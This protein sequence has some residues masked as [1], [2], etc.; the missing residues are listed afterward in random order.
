MTANTM[1]TN[2]GR[3]GYRPGA[4]RP[5]VVTQVRVGQSYSV[6]GVPGVT[7]ARVAQVGPTGLVLDLDN[8]TTAVL[9][10]NEAA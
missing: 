8:Q 1:T 7:T 10:L 6:T 2:T 4:G 5:P 3:G 9:Q